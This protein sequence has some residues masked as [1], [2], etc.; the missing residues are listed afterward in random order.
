MNIN[1]ILGVITA[2]SI[3]VGASGC[4]MFGGRDAQQPL[5]PSA[6]NTSGEGT[7]DARVGEN[8]NTDIEVRVKHLSAPSKVEPDASVYVVWIEPQGSPIQN[9]GALQVDEDLVGAFNA[10]T[11]HRIFR[12]SVTPEPSARMDNPSH[13]PVFT[14]EVAV[15]DE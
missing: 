2:L 9:I 12:L 4:G 3:A 5:N 7:V 8:G 11:P 6:E 15:A 1:Q 10:T 14:S 13:E